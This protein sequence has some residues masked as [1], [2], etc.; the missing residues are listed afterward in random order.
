M[1]SAKQVTT[2]AFDLSASERLLKFLEGQG[3]GSV[4]IVPLTPDAS[5]RNYFRIPWKKGN[6][7]AAVYPEPFDPDFHPYLDVTRLFLENGI[8][9]PEIYAVDGESGLIV[10]EDLGD[11]QLFRV[12]EATPQEQ[13]DEYKERAVNL[14]AQI[15]NATSAAYDRQSIASRLA[16]D[17][18][19]LSWELDFFLE[20][21]FG[22]LRQETLRHAEAAELKAELNDVSAEL[23][24]RPRVLCHRDFHAA[25]LMVDADDRLRIV[26]HQDARMGPVTYDLVSF[27]LDRR[28][29]PPSLAELRNYRLFLLEERRLLGL[30]ALDPDE[31]AQEF[32]LMTIQRGLKAIGTFSYQTAVCD[33]G[34][35]YEHFIQP[36]LCIVLQA[37]DWLDR[38]PAL[39]RILRER[40]DMN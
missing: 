2:S 21:Y 32:R 15:Q 20:H 3:S 9:V 14:I 23:A 18:P 10:Q 37:A 22:S 13:C 26:D 5:T 34:S 36:T 24:A 16:F 19:K 12:Y 29:E 7:V 1:S 38:F 35:A 6:A 11:R 39:R 31:V 40:I 27:L 33:R 8:P 25:N 30:E 17:E 4:L 28:P